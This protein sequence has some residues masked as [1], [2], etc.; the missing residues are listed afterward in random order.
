VTKYGFATKGFS[1]LVSASS[2]LELIQR[3]DTN[4]I[5]ADYR[6]R[7][8][9]LLGLMFEERISGLWDDTLFPRLK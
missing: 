3:M 6:M 4:M 9:Y 5:F 8:E 1:K 2:T 7:R